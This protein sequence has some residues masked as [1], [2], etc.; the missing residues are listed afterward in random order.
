MA[1]LFLNWQVPSPHM[2]WSWYCILL[3][4][5]SSNGPTF[6]HPWTW[7]DVCLALSWSW[8]CSGRCQP[9]HTKSLSSCQSSFIMHGLDQF[10]P[11]ML[12]LTQNSS[13]HKVAE[14]FFPID[15]TSYLTVLFYLPEIAGSGIQKLR[16]YRRTRARESQHHLGATWPVIPSDPKDP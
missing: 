2:S 7:A 9:L 14:L 1:W 4:C 5:L 12:K 13:L 10:F 11:D 16:K 15:I 3:G 6:G 8:P